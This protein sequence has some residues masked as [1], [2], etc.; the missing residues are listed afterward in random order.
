MH[1]KSLPLLCIIRVTERSIFINVIKSKMFHTEFQ[2]QC[3]NSRI[4]NENRNPVPSAFGFFLRNWQ[5]KLMSQSCQTKLLNLL[6]DLEFRPKR[7][8]N[9]YSVFENSI[10]LSM[11][12]MFREL[13]DIFNSVT[14]ILK[15]LR[16]VYFSPIQFS[17]AQLP[18]SAWVSKQITR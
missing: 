9:L 4:W 17:V 8:S 3:S 16:F 15:C 5:I 12:F 1:W 2:T 18:D 6:I 7:N 11:I 13:R 10:H 14:Q